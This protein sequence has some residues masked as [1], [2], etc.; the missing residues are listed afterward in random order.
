MNCLA[1]ATPENLA[2]DLELLCGCVTGAVAAYKIEAWLGQIGFTEVRVTEKPESHRPASSAPLTVMVSGERRTI[3]GNAKPHNPLQP[4]IN[5]RLST[6]KSVRVL[7]PLRSG[8]FAG[9]L[10]DQQDANDDDDGNHHRG[11]RPA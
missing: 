7:K 6:Q 2:G 5:R 9:P 3:P 10:R 4:P 8:M 11:N 1:T